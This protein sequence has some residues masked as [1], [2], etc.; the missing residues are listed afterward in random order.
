MTIVRMFLYFQDGPIGSGNR[1]V[2]VLDARGGR[3]RIFYP[4]TLRLFTISEEEYQAAARAS[5]TSE[6]SLRG[7]ARII[8]ARR[9]MYRRLRKE[10]Q[11]RAASGGAPSKLGWSVAATREVLELLKAAAETAVVLEDVE[12]AEDEAADNT[13]GAD[14]DTS[15]NTEGAEGAVNKRVRKPRGPK[16][17]SP[18]RSPKTAKAKAEGKAK[19]AAAPKAAKGKAK[20]AAPAAG[21]RVD[22]KVITVLTKENPRKGD[23]AKRFDAMRTGMTIGEYVKAAVKDLGISARMAKAEV[24]YAEKDG[25]IETKAPKE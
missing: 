19:K 15:T 7:M 22:A 2:L 16:G 23:R 5:R 11:E 18:A 9:A 8:R 6:Q 1:D 21:G 12:E 3:R 4:S 24:W 10:G 13:E 14:M 17:A 25:L 20:K